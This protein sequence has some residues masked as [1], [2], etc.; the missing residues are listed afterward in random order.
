MFDGYEVRTMFERAG[1]KI[2][3]FILIALLAV[4]LAG[5]VI[6]LYIGLASAQETSDLSGSWAVEVERADDG[7]IDAAASIVLDLALTPTTSFVI[8]HE[9]AGAWTPQLEALLDYHHRWDVGLEWRP[10]PT[11]SISIGRRWQSELSIDYGG[12][13]TYVQVWSGF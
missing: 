7:Q 5:L 1:N 6:G 2:V 3:R 10:R 4:V 12:P 11:L 13:W 9:Q 8:G